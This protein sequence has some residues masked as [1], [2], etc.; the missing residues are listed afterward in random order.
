MSLCL[1]NCTDVR[2]AQKSPLEFVHYVHLTKHN[3]N[4]LINY[5]TFVQKCQLTIIE[6]F[7]F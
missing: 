1:K 3:H 7:I 6:Q 4:Y 5:N 2:N